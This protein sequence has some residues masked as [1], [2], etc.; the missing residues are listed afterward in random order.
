MLRIKSSVPA[1]ALVIALG[2]TGTAFAMDNQDGNSQ[3]VTAAL[4]AKTSL[5]QAISS[6]EQQS[7]GR[8]FRI[9]LE[10]HDGSYAYKIKVIAADDNVSEVSVDPASGQVLHTKAEGLISRVFDGEDRTEAAKLKQAQTTLGDAIAAAEQQAGG[11]AIEAGYEN[12]NGR[13]QFQVSVAKDHNV[14]DVK[15]DSATAK[16]IRIEAAGDREQ[17]DGEQHED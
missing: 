16:V 11:K 6:A 1:F 2:S 10:E 13:M 4:A 14:S 12:E 7:G 5:T 15:I 9:G 17:H 8:A 3:E